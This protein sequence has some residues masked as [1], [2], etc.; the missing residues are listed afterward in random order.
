M[1]AR[2]R[3]EISSLVPPLL[4]TGLY[5]GLIVGPLARPHLGI[6]GLVLVGLLPLLPLP[7]LVRWSG[8]LRQESLFLL[9]RHLSHAALLYL[10]VGTQLNLRV[11]A[12]STLLPDNLRANAW[13]AV[14]CLFVAALPA[15]LERRPRLL[16]WAAVLSVLVWLGVTAAL[17]RSSES[18]EQAARRAPGTAPVT[19]LRHNTPPESHNLLLIVVDTLRADRLGFMGNP[20]VQTPQLDAL[21][22]GATVYPDAV[23]AAPWTLSSF[24]TLLT[25]RSPTF[26]QAHP[27]RDALGTD[28]KGGRFGIQP[29]RRDI[30]TLAE[31]LQAAGYET[32]FIGTNPYLSRINGLDRGFGHFDVRLRT[33]ERYAA[34]LAGLSRVGLHPLEPLD[35]CFDAQTMT[36]R[37]LD[38]LTRSHPRPFFLL[39]HYMDPHWPYEPPPPYDDGAGQLDQPVPPISRLSRRYDAEVAG[40]DGAVGRLLSGLSAA[41]LAENTVVVLTADH[42][43]AFGEHGS[44]VAWEEKPGTVEGAS[45]RAILHGHTQYQ[46][47]LHVPFVLRLPGGEGRIDPRIMRGVDV[48]PTLLALAGAPAP[49]GLEG[50]AGGIAFG[51]GAVLTESTLSGY[52]KKSW[53]EGGYKLIWK[54]GYPA[55][56]ELELYNLQR[57]PGEKQNLIAGERARA[58][59]LRGHLEAYLAALRSK[60][61]PP[62]AGRDPARALPPEEAARLKALGYVQ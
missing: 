59:E 47:L 1:L 8:R 22:A 53:R 6:P 36:T 55:G 35:P 23:S 7:V 56:E 29:L 30:P 18:L 39:L 57:D 14:G 50:K 21:A 13:C 41:G 26:H 46:E 48:M 38:W 61:P 51:E 17:L 27:L 54:A 49:E 15:L 42:G 52:E 37:G 60:T 40:L 20:T 25:G 19:P 24:A 3:L 2:L 33:V 16:R 43:E 32:A 9:V 58:E 12:G 31:A 4:W 11:L 28:L 34:L 44:W 5:L 45:S 10:V 62:D